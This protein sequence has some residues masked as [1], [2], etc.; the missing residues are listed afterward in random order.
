M[1]RKKKNKTKHTNIVRIRKLRVNYELR[2]DY[3]KVLTEYIKTFPKEHRKVRVDNIVT[4]EGQRKDEWVRIIAEVQ[5]GKIISFLLD[6]S[7]KFIFENV[8][9]DAI[10]KLR[11]DYIKR[12]KRIN[13]ALR[14]KAEKLDVSIEDYSFM[15]IQPYDYQKKAI[16][17]FE[18][19]KGLA[20]LGDEPGVGKSLAAFGFAVKHNLKTLVICPASLK[21]NWKKEITKFAGHKSFIFKYKPKK[22]S[23]QIAYT[24]DESLFHIINYESIETYAKFEYSHKCSGNMIQPDGRNGKCGWQQIDLVKKYK[25]C[26]ICENVG[27]IKTR[28]KNLVYF[29]DKEDIFLNPDDYDLI[30]IDECHRIKEQKTTWTRIIKK[31]FQDIP[32]KLLLSGT[33]IKS[34]PYEFFSALNFIDPKMWNNSHQFGVKYC[35]AYEDNFGWDYSGASN[36]EELFE[37]VSPFFLRRLK[38]D[39]LKDLPPKTYTNIPIELTDKEYREYL[40]IEKEKTE[41]DKGYLAKIHALKSFAGIVKANRAIEMI[42]DIVDAGEKIVIFSDYVN[43]AKF[44]YEHF[45]DIAVL[46]TGELD[47]TAKQDAVDNF[48]ETDEIKI[49]SGMI[50]ASG[51]GLTL[52][53]ANKAMFLGFAWTPA[54]MEQCEDR[55]HRA[56]TTADN[57]QII[58]L[59][60]QDTIDEDIEELLIE[61]AQVVSKVLDSKDF[62]KQVNVSDESIF[63]QLV[64][65][66]KEK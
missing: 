33:V 29:R 28:A 31:A 60:C 53:A 14:L 1:L 55:L 45:K 52:T 32:R 35:A 19:N 39:V 11:V 46:H 51:E 17:F 65:R 23:K 50:E 4:P 42:Q 40:K 20:I 59:I 62:K 18:I 5:M 3:L 49:F 24:K 38:K 26:P 36:L 15:K 7:I 61:K 12:L 34:R 22:K 2:Y 13:E 54:S 58:K 44:I 16:K 6:N 10:E 64:Q 43:T 66:L 63:K 21:L 8:P 56:S 57:V 27:T 48:Q 47:I 37:R 9:A 41:E 25:K 30:I